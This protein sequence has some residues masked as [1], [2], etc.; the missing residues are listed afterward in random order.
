MAAVMKRTMATATRVVG[1]ETGNGDG[2][3]SDGNG[4]KGGGQAT[5]SRAITLAM[6]TGRQW[7]RGRGWRV[8]NRARARAARAMEMTM[9]VV[10]N[11]EGEGSKAMTMAT[12]VAGEQMATAPVLS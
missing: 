4:D 7:Q 3:K 11:K 8:T 6:V 10:G 12:R 2:G 5:A 9:R 1:N